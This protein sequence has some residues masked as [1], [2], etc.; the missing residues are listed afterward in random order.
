MFV[1][2]RFWDLIFNIS[3]F[4]NF[5]DLQ[6]FFQYL[7][8]FPAEFKSE[9]N[10][11]RSE[12]T[13]K[14]IYQIWNNVFLKHQSA[15]LF[16]A[17]IRSDILNDNCNFRSCNLLGTVRQSLQPLRQ[18][19]VH[20]IEFGKIFVSV[21]KPKQHKKYNSLEMCSVRSPESVPIF[22]KSLNFHVSDVG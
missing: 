5:L 10:I 8:D 12:L 14:T 22:A 2:N 17:K 1:A 20:Q 13:M 4:S 3:I 11:F 18:H 15:V 21:W 7:V 19:V 9:I 16:I 6:F